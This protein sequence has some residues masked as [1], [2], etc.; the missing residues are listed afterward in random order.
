MKTDNAILAEH[1]GGIVKAACECI[2]FE[3]MRSF[4][5]AFDYVIDDDKFI[6]G[7]IRCESTDMEIDEFFNH[8][9]CGLSVKLTKIKAYGFTPDKREMD[10][11]YYSLSDAI[12][13]YFNENYGEL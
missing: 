6:E 11:L 2:Y 9:A 10:N 8:A 3:P 4:N 5:R 12:D 1:Y 7:T 13:E